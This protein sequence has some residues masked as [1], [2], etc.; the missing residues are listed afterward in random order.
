M[1][2]SD[3]KNLG[4]AYRSIYE[5]K[6]DE[7]EFKPHMMYDPKTGKG[8][9]AE[10]PEDHERMK[11]MGYSHEKI[12]EIAPLAAVVP[13]V[14]GMAGRAAA[15]AVAKRGVGALGQ[16]VAA[17]TATT[18]TT[19]AGDKVVDKITSNDESAKLPRQMLD[20][21][22][23]VMVVKNN[24]VI[25]I[26]KSKEKEYLKKGW[27]LAE[28][29]EEETLD[30]DASNFKSAVAR[31]KKTKSVKDLK[32][33][34]VSFDRVYKVGALTDKELGQL[35]TMIG[36]KLIKLGFYEEVEEA[37]S[38]EQQA[39]IAIS[40]K[41]KEDMKNE[42]VLGAVGGAML[43][44]PLG[45]GGAIAGGIGGSAAQD[46]LKK[47]V[48]EGSVK[49]L[50]MKIDKI[51]AK[52]NKD[53]KLKPH[54]KKFASMA[55]NTM[56]IEKSLEKSLPSSVSGAAM[57]GLLEGVVIEALDPVDDKAND[58]KFKNRKDKDI[59]NDGD[60]DSSDE[61]LHNRRAKVDDAIDGGKKPAKKEEK[62]D[63]VLKKKDKP[64][65]KDMSQ[66]VAKSPKTSEIEKIGESF[67]A[68]LEAALKSDGKDKDGEELSKK[69]TDDEKIDEKE[70]VKGK[71]FI[72][73]HDA[74]DKDLENKE[75][76]SKEVTTK[77]GSDATKPKSGKRDIDSTTGDTKI[78]NPVKEGTE[79]MRSLVDMARAHLAGD[80]VDFSKKVLKKE[81][82][83]KNPYDARF[84]EAKAFMARMN[85]KRGDC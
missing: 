74:S 70:P 9:K 14:A 10:K 43:G 80:K 41:E 82:K 12:D 24:K 50:A 29:V 59:D 44:A 67:V 79:E 15:G 51:V 54:A 40:K 60:V 49:D 23:D 31:I 72:K 66:P 35:D 36:D 53:S 32:K 33:L 52:M 39:A 20:P 42:G 37:V 63:E 84:K 21:K 7:K 28:Q 22:K 65:A 76:E 71:E 34:E 1:K 73:K 69:A 8:H 11:K 81:V 68:M 5:A 85:K 2:T 61:Y 55:M 3:I 58:K 13:A 16:K 64:V 18:A 78:V 56:D 6:I 48:K 26:D 47:K 77:A 57:I 38:P 30:E 17:K 25:V 27:G 45:L 4:N 75:E 83:E 19:A 46:L 62:E